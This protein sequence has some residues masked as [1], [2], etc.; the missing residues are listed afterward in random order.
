MTP[1]GGVNT[2]RLDFKRLLLQQSTKIGPNKLSAAEQLKLSRQQQSSQVQLSQRNQKQSIPQQ[3][4]PS[5][6]RALS[7]RSPWRFQTP[8]SDVL[9][10]TII[11]DAAAE[12]KAMKPS[13]ENYYHSTN[14]RPNT[15]R[16]LDL[17]GIISQSQ[18]KMI[19]NMDII[20][21]YFHNNSNTQSMAIRNRQL[22]AE[23]FAKSTPVNTINSDIYKIR[24]RSE[25]PSNTSNFK[26]VSTSPS[27]PTLETA[28]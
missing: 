13:P 6:A 9:S 11:E 2:A 5:I 28:L 1:T 18:K 19:N 3:N 21:T 27:A 17:S 23:F 26:A 8:R 24:S 22:K 12:E 20:P 15:K 4:M 10:S 14:N 25:S 16:Q 7:P